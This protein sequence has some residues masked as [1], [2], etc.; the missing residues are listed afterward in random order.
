MSSIDPE[1]KMVVAA[2]TLLDLNT[3]LYAEAKAAKDEVG[4]ARL[5][6]V[7]VGAAFDTWLETLLN[8]N[9][10]ICY[11]QGLKAV[12]KCG[13]IDPEWSLK[14][15]SLLNHSDIIDQIKLVPYWAETTR[16]NRAGM[17]ISFTNF[18]DR[19]TDGLIR[20]ARPSK[21]GVNTTFYRFREKVKTEA[22]TRVEWTKFLAVLAR[23]SLRNCL[24]AKLCLQGGKRISEVLDL[25]WD[26][27]DADRKQIAFV[28]KKSRRVKETI[29]TFPERVF[30]DLAL[31]DKTG[32]R[33]GLVFVTRTGKRVFP[34]QIHPA[35]VR[36][37][38]KA[39]IQKNVHPHML[40]VSCV[41]Y[42][43]AQG[44]SAS[45]VKKITGHCS[46]EMVETYNK[47]PAAKN[48]SQQV[49]LV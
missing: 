10:R 46:S 49:S 11:K 32:L 42:L 35:F 30:E 6:T 25:T 45:D 3:A 2:R 27:V 15:F 23:Q 4:W 47:G 13:L 12:V 16:Q 38:K 19:R 7:T 33:E 8:P 31:L 24:I 22:L 44:Y 48:P 26:R 34:N 41:T 37:G 1:E 17:F 5:G 9:T 14:Q 29:I 20:K 18:L 39:G 21:G 36:A 43:L 40:R 28:Q